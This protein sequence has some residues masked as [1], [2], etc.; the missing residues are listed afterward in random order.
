MELVAGD[1]REVLVIAST[2]ERDGFDDRTRFAAYLSLGGGV[3]PTWLDLF[4][5][6]VRTVTEQPDPPD[7][8]DA[9]IELGATEPFSE[10]TVER[11]DPGWVG[12]GRADPRSRARRD[13]RTLDRSPRGRVRADLGR[14]EAVD[15]RARGPGGGVLPRGRPGAGRHLPV[16]I[17]VTDEPTPDHAAS[18]AANQALWE[19][20]TAV[21]AAGDF[22]DLAG[23][24]AGGV[25]LRDDEIAAV[26]DIR[27]RSLLHLQCHFGIDT[28]SWARLGA[29]VTGA[30]FSPAAIRLAQELADGPR[31]RRRAFRRIERVRPA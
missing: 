2:D 1:A 20:W 4:A 5:D 12:Y 16:V 29:R 31:V 27:G 22:Y 24:R 21:H 9:R 3:D 15:P 23:F 13:R 28:L 18:F 11:V 25:R 7:F 6:A 10:V 30:D 14:R 8:L 17:A 26:G 19:A